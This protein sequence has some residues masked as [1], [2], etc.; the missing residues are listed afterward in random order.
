MSPKPGHEARELSAPGVDAAGAK[1]RKAFRDAEEAVKGKMQKEFGDEFISTFV[2]RMRSEVNRL[3][4][5][6]E[7]KVRELLGARLNSAVES[8][9]Q[10]AVRQMWGD[11]IQK[12]IR[13]TVES[14]EMI[15]KMA[16]K[17][18]ELL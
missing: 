2:E 12:E 10:A 13:K 16:K 18:K 8:Q 14:P 11:F 4:I 15:L 7:E 5:N 3:P 17:L 6:I 1:L 9:V